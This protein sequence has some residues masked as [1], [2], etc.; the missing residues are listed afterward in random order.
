MA[1]AVVALHPRTVA[2]STWS[3]RSRSSRSRAGV[4][5]LFLVAGLLAGCGSTDHVDDPSGGAT[6]TST[7]AASTCVSAAAI[8]RDPGHYVPPE[9]AHRVPAPP[10]GSKICRIDPQTRGT[11]YAITSGP[12]G[13]EILEYYGPAF[14][15]NGCKTDAIGPP[16]STLIVAGDLGLHFSCPKGS[17]TVVAPDSGDHYVIA[18]G[19]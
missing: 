2:T 18:W 15:A 13:R 11:L 7:V 16:G 10:P 6:T 9:L 17:G 12:G 14:R 8:Q 19:N 5:A 1:E 4:I 3:H